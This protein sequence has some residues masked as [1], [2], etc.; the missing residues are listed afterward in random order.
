MLNAISA[1]RLQIWSLYTKVGQPGRQPNRVLERADRVNVGMHP[2]GSRLAGQ[3]TW[4]EQYGLSP[5]APQGPVSLG[6]TSAH[7][8]T[9][10]QFSLRKESQGSATAPRCKVNMSK[11]RP[12]VSF[13]PWLFLSLPEAFCDVSPPLQMWKEWNFYGHRVL[14]S[15][16]MHLPRSVVVHLIQMCAFRVYS[17]W[18]DF[19]KDTLFSDVAPSVACLPRVHEVPHTKNGISYDWINMGMS[20]LG[21][22]S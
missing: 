17:V 5:A 21:Y 12:A 1:C 7:L 13:R 3:R 18:E 4:S 8:Q 15:E 6:S 20:F 9:M 10:Q 16:V 14:R 22:Y 11:N 2:S 19:L